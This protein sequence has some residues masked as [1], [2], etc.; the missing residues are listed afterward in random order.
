MNINDLFNIKQEDKGI[1]EFYITQQ[2][3]KLLEEYKTRLLNYGAVEIEKEEIKIRICYP[4]KEIEDTI[5]DSIRQEK[6]NN[7]YISEI[8]LFN[9]VND[10][11]SQ[12]MSRNKYKN[13]DKSLIVKL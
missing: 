9:K 5:E 13:S 2:K 10:N 11:C 7:F 8:F 12:V 1:D 6:S 3:Q 4:K